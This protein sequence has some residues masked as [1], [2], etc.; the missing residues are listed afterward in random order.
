MLLIS[1]EFGKLV[2]VANL[3]AWPVAY[4][5]MQRWLASFA[6]RIDMS[7]WVFVAAAL[8]AFAIA[9]LTVGSVAA[10]AASTKPINALRYE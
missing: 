9:C 10:R 3:V 1:G 8:G 5:L 6:Y 2:L 7:A 4:F